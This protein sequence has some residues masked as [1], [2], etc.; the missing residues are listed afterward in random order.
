MPATRNPLS[1]EPFAELRSTP[2]AKPEVEID[3][4]RPAIPKRELLDIALIPAPVP[5]SI[6]AGGEHSQGKGPEASSESGMQDPLLLKHISLP[7]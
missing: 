4:F 7:G 3:P 5:I 1:I 6:R 2:A